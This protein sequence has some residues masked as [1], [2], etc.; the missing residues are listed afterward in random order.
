MYHWTTSFKDEEFDPSRIECLNLTT[1]IQ[2]SPYEKSPADDYE[3]VRLKSGHGDREQAIVQIV[4]FPSLTAYRRGGGELAQKY[5]AEEQAAEPRH[6]A[7]IPP[8]LRAQHKRVASQDQLTGDEGFRTTTICK[9]VVHLQWGMQSLLTEEAGTS[10]H[11]D[12]MNKRNG[13]SM[14]RY[15]DDR[16]GC[17][18]LWDVYKAVQG[19]KTIFEV[20]DEYNGKG[21][22]VYQ[23]LRGFLP[24]G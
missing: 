7:N 6:N 5:F 12:A 17:V 1:M 8:E 20:V 19:G 9:S 15:E 24:G 22:T 18:E 11:S 14:D 3:P 23:S 10:F 4:C 13:Q 2:N 16:K 21:G